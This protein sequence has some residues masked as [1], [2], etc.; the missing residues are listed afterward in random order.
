MAAM[1]SKESRSMRADSDGEDARSEHVDRNSHRAV[2]SSGLDA[3]DAWL[4]SSVITFFAPAFPTSSSPSQAFCVILAYGICQP[5]ASPGAVRAFSPSVCPACVSLSAAGKEI[6]RICHWC[7]VG[8]SQLDLLDD[9]SMG[10][11]GEDARL[12]DQRRAQESYAAS[13]ELV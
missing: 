2:T 4:A 9:D 10:F 11:G 13:L 1:N 3:S 7:S 12:H 6:A 5:D 8:G